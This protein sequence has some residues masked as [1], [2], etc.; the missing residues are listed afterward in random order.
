MAAGAE[1]AV[2]VAAQQR[3]IGSSLAAARWRRQRR[4]QRQRNCATAAAAWWRLLQQR[5]CGGG[6]QR[7]GGRRW[8][9]Q[10][11]GRRQSTAQDKRVAQQEDGEMQCNN[12]LGKRYPIILIGKIHCH[13]LSLGRTRRKKMMICKSG[14]WQ[15]GGVKHCHNSLPCSKSI[16]PFGTGVL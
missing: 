2:V 9:G 15:G 3:D 11:Q 8:M 4:Q 10:G 6:A 14:D 7:D 12:Q 16:S 13:S 5:Q 1:S